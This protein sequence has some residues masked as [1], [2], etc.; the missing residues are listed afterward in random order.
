MR[1]HDLWGAVLV[2]D[3]IVLSGFLTWSITIFSQIQAYS[4]I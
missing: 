4:S 3:N 1:I 2:N